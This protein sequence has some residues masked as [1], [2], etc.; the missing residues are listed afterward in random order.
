MTQKSDLRRALKA[1]LSALPWEMAHSSSSCY[2]GL[3]AAH[4]KGFPAWGTAE[5]TS[6]ALLP[7]ASL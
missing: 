7:R 2:R 4:P 5:V 6:L 1:L 3:S